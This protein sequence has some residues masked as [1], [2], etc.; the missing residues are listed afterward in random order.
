MRKYILTRLW[1]GVVVIFLLSLVVFTLTRLA[2]GS[3]A[4]FMAGPRAT[5]AD[6]L[7][8]E[9][10]LGLDKPFS[11]QL[12][13]WLGNFARMDFGASYIFRKPALQVFISR[14]PA[15]ILLMTTANVISLALAM[16]LGIY[17]GLK[18]GELFDRVV[19][20][21]C[22]IGISVPVFWTG[23]VAIFIFA[24]LLR[25]L[26]LGGMLTPATEFSIWDLGRHMIIPVSVLTFLYTA[27]WLRFVRAG[28]IEVLRMDYV[29]LGRAKGVQNRSILVKHVL[30][31]ALLPIITVVGV[32]VRELFVGSVVVEAATGWP[33][34]GTLIYH[35][36]RVRD[37]TVVSAAVVIVGL[38]VVLGNLGADIAYGF[39]DP[40]IKYR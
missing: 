18:R 39:A 25:W 24:V 16:V 33:G 29:L 38:S 27:Y 5:P 19:T 8:I 37:L 17:A 15:T 6:I 1:Q 4:E 28:V 2:P 20:F 10:E 36:A 26:P 40:R 12:L 13:I 7:R 11:T 31:N 23:I 3:P 32:S 34:V 14:L 35:S 9:K 22:F 30:R 21:I